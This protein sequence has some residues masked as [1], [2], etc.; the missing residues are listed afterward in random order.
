MYRLN[1]CVIILTLLVYLKTDA[2][3]SQGG[4]PF[5]FRSE[6]IQQFKYEDLA[7]TIAPAFDID[8]AKEEDRNQVGTVRFAAPIEVNYNLENSGTWKI[9]DN[10]DQIWQLKVKSKDALGIF[11]RYNRFLL[12]EGVELFMYNENKSQIFGAYTAQN[13]RSS[14]Q[15]MTGMID[16]EIALLELY[17]PIAVEGQ[18]ELQI[19]QVMHA[20]QSDHIESHTDYNAYA[21]FGFGESLPCHID[22]NCP[23]GDGMNLQKRSIAR[24]A[25]VFEEGVG[26][27]T[28]A[29]INN[30]SFDETAYI[31]SAFHCQAGFTPV[32]DLWRFDFQ[33]EKQFCSDNNEPT[34]NSILGCHYISGREESDFVLFELM[35]SIPLSY[36]VYYNGW[37]RTPDLLPQYSAVLHHPKGDVK[38]VS[39]DDESSVIIGTE[40]HWSNGVTTPPDYHF[41]SILDAGT[42]EPGSSGAPYLNENGLIVGQLHGGNANCDEFVTYYGRFSKSW[43][44]GISPDT[45]LKDWLDPDNL[46]GTTLEGHDPN[47]PQLGFATINGIALTSNGDPINY[48]N[49][50]LEGSVSDNLQTGTNGK[51]EFENIPLNVNYELAANKS[52][53]PLNGVTTFDLVLIQRH[54]LGIES[55]DTPEKMLAADVNQSGTITT[56]DLVAIRRVILEIDE[57]FPAGKSWLFTPNN[58]QTGNLIPSGF[59]QTFIG[60][61]LGDVNENVD[62][63]QQ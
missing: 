6:Y 52:S 33:Y 38:K 19:S 53:D 54:I 21:G 56:L 8:K 1:T 31:L 25:R 28:G 48:V 23:E 3:I 50:M 9:L 5:S 46:V 20:Y 17:V 44:A 57:I 60:I 41:R 7:T 36:N 39:V 29:L 55:L 59:N 32:Y 30:A 62:P 34:Y 51:F 15:F 35:E 16:G 24:I 47:I 14:Q 37:D 63:H 26:W 27:C 58:I 13:N 11:F 18:S 40:I 22:S 2:Q 49:I 43:D 45:R 10:G 4:L 42:I 61:K 12:A